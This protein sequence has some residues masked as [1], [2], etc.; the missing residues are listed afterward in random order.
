MCSFRS[1]LRFIYHTVLKYIAAARTPKI[2]PSLY[3]YL[4][5]LLKMIENVPQTK[6][7][8][9]GEAFM[10]ASLACP[11]K[12]EFVENS[13]WPTEIDENQSSAKEPKASINS[14][15][16]FAIKEKCSNVSPEVRIIISGSGAVAIYICFSI[17]VFV[18]FC[19]PY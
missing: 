5:P 18:N 7:I 11:S 3:W 4:L 8:I 10:T 16:H 12:N 15:L 2:S 13:I 9:I 19:G 6:H 1:K 14:S 17:L